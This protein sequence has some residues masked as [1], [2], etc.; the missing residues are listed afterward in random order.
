MLSRPR[1]CWAADIAKAS[2]ITARSPAVLHDLVALA[3]LVL[4]VQMRSIC[5]Q[6]HPARRQPLP[7]RGFELL[8]LP[9]IMRAQ[10][11]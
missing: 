3:R 5:A 2:L 11:R 9:V 10:I 4:T 1:V 8:Q 7:R 6:A